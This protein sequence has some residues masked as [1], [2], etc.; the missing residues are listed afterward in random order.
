MGLL[1][2]FGG[3]CSPFGDSKATRWSYMF[4]V[5][6]FQPRWVTSYISECGDMRAL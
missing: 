3:Y 1:L 2:R 5:S 4:H 6:F